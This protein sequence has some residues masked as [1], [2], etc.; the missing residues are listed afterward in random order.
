MDIVKVL[1]NIREFFWPLLDPLD[2]TK[3][4]RIDINDCQVTENE[5]DL[6]LKYIGDYK[7]SEDDRRKE[8]ESKATIF[9]GTFGVATTILINLEKEFILNTNITNSLSNL[10]FIILITLTIVYLCRAVLF[11]IKTL[12][13]RKYFIFGFPDYMLIDYKTKKKNILRD[14]YNC[15][16]ANMKEINIKVDYMT[17]AQEYFKRAIVVVAVMAILF[18]IQY[19]ILSNDITLALSQFLQSIISNQGIAI[20][21]VVLI[22]ILI[23]AL[24]MQFYR[25]KKLKKQIKAY[26]K[27]R[28]K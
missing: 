19:A 14:Q 5:I 16:S 12:Q 15:V 25:I 28:L 11:A 2:E 27:D 4:K 13:R 26:K 21:I 6:A 20:S 18:L 8:V 1:K 24:F 22:L 3:V 23:I 10:C 17:M 7:K 9:I